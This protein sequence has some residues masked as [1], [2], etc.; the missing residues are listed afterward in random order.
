MLV[1]AL[2]SRAVPTHLCRCGSCVLQHIRLESVCPHHPRVRQQSITGAVSGS[3]PLRSPSAEHAPLCNTRPEL[4]P[5]FQKLSNPEL[6]GKEG[7]RRGVLHT[8]LVVCSLRAQQSQHG[9]M[10][11]GLNLPGFSVWTGVKPN[12]L[13]VPSPLS[14]PGNSCFIYIPR[15]WNSPL[16]PVQYY[17]AS[18]LNI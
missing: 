18:F 9:A 15:V 10:T 14:P 11:P 7:P 1:L 3:L 5:F 6:R 16:I 4:C 8:G 13:P 12:Y 2:L 17:F